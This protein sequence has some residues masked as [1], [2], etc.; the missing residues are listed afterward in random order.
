MY[1]A[2]AFSGREVEKFETGHG[3]YPQTASDGPEVNQRLKSTTAAAAAATGNG[4][5]NGKGICILQL[6]V[7]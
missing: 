3:T 5:S 6:F 7:D 2:L 4:H 1:V